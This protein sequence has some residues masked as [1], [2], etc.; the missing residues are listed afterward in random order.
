MKPLC[1]L[2]SI[3][4][5][6][7]AFL[8][9]A[10]GQSRPF[11]ERM[12][13]T[14]MTL[15][16]DYP[17]AESGRPARWSYE[18]AVVLKG[19]ERVW[20]DTG[21]GNYFKYIQRSIDQFVSDDGT[22]KT[23]RLDDYNL[24]NI[25]NGRVLL[26]LYK[27]TAKEKYLKTA[28]LLRDQLKTQPRTSDGGFWHK[29][30]YPYQM[31]LDGLYMGEPFYAEYAATFHED[32]DFDD[33]A[34]Q[35]S[36]MEQ[37]ARDAKTGLLYHGW[38]AS[39][40]ERW[41]DPATGHS[42]NFWGRAMGWYAMALVDTLDYFPKDHPKRT[43]LLAILRRLAAAIEKYQ[44]PKSALWYQVLDKGRAQGNYFESSASCMFVYALAKGVRQGY[45]PAAYLKVARKGY[46]GIVNWF[47][48]TDANGQVNLKGTVSVAGL[49]GNPY[50]DGSY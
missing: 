41:A 15:W 34:Q 39:R 20:R 8:I 11:S 28:T 38:D 13:S 9:A 40:R 35:F 23:Y 6:L 2:I 4:V 3:S 44:E 48:E 16:Q 21:D 30:I 7:T 14:V 29:K 12:A 5:L 22:I 1:K 43:A 17:G 25:L 18:Q 45:L 27:V 10:R 31:W 26:L 24:D 46:Q 37:H 42:P 47:V 32:A 19:M 50:R 33:I 36:L 49:G